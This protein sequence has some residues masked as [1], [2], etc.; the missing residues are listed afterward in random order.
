MRRLFNNLVSVVF[1][2]VK[3]CLMKL[4]L[5][6]SFS[7]H[8]IERF[9]PN[10]VTEFNRGSHVKIGRMVRVH[11]GCKIKAR[12]GAALTL[13]EGAKLNYN[14]ILA[15]HESITIGAGTVFGPS[16]YV[17]DHDHDYHHALREDRY[18]S[19]PVVIGKGCWIGANAVILRG[20]TIGDN[21]VIGAGCVIKGDIPAN[22]VVVQKRE[23]VLR[24]FEVAE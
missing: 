13:E 1:T 2:F 3:F 20:S 23:T 16:V 8:P 6:S 17:Y 22:T 21:C 15:C 9:S 12:S 10:V 24:T 11:S 5:G 18:L 19:A 14:C 7:F 4:F